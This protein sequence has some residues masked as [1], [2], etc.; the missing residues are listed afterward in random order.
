MLPDAGK[1]SSSAAWGRSTPSRVPGRE[2]KGAMMPGS[3]PLRPASSSIP[4]PSF[5]FLMSGPLLRKPQAR[6][7]SRRLPHPVC[8]SLPRKSYSESSPH[9]GVGHPPRLAFPGKPAQPLADW[10]GRAA[11]APGRPLELWR[12]RRRRRGWPC[13]RP[14]SEPSLQVAAAT[15]ATRPTPH[16]VLAAAG[17]SAARRRGAAA[18]DSGRPQAGGGPSAASTT[19]DHGLAATQAT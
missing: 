5:D 8:Q 4:A 1:A 12:R 17:V 18:G 6:P 16:L 19:P 9:S 3:R 10:G 13:S 2:E 11:H 7:V 14:G 15:P